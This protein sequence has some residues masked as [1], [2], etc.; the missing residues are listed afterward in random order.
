MA[1]STSRSKCGRCALAAF[2]VP[3]EGGAGFVCRARIDLDG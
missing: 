2:E 3:E 1:R